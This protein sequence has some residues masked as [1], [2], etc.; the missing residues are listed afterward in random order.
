MICSTGDMVETDS[1]FIC[2]KCPLRSVLCHRFI[3]AG[4]GPFMQFIS[5]SRPFALAV[6]S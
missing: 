5:V 6:S 4:G 2:I 3:L 1:P